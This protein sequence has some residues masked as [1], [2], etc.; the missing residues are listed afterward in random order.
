MVEKVKEIKLS[1][2]RFGFANKTIIDNINIEFKCG[3]IYALVGHNGA[4]KTTIVD[5]LMGL[6]G[7]SYDGEISVNHISI[8][9]LNMG[10]FRKKHMGITE[11]EQQLIADSIYRNICIEKEYKY[12]RIR[13]V[14]KLLNMYE[15]VNKLPQGINTPVERL[16]GGE[17]QK[18]AIARLL[19]KKPTIMIFDEPTSAL[20]LESSCKFLDYLQKIKED[21]IIIMITHDEKVINQ[22]DYKI[23]I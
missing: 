8:K 15:F 1:Q 12:K 14:L 22:C 18:I 10:M 23:R 6:Y 3:S 7:D 5:L 9:K 21:R 20:D 13:G 19:L 16:S 2:I 4:G 11:Q 17:K